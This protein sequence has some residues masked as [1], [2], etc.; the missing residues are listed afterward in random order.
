[1]HADPKGKSKQKGSRGCR[2]ED[3]SVCVG[4]NQSTAASEANSDTHEQRRGT[5]VRKVKFDN[6]NEG[7][8]IKKVFDP[9]NMTVDQAGGSGISMVCHDDCDEVANVTDDLDSGMIALAEQWDKDHADDPRTD[10]EAFVELLKDDP[11]ER[12]NPS[13]VFPPPQRPDFDDEAEIAALRQRHWD[14]YHS[15]QAESSSDTTSDTVSVTTDNLPAGTSSAA[16]SGSP[17]PDQE[18]DPREPTNGNAK[19]R[20]KRGAYMTAKRWMKSRAKARPA[21]ASENTGGFDLSRIPSELRPRMHP[22]VLERFVNGEYQPTEQELQVYER[23]QRTKATLVS[24][25]QTNYKTAVRLRNDQNIFAVPG[26]AL[27]DSGADIGVGISRAIA[28]QLDITWDEPYVMHGIGGSGGCLGRSSKKI[29]IHIGGDGRIDDTN[30]DPYDGCFTLWVQPIIITDDICRSIGH[31]CLIGQAIWT[32]CLASQDYFEEVLDISPAWFRHKC[33]LLR[34]S[35]PILSRKPLKSFKAACFLADSNVY[36]EA[37]LDDC[38]KPAVGKPVDTKPAPLPAPTSSSKVLAGPSNEPTA[39][40]SEPSSSKPKAPATTQAKQAARKAAAALIAPSSPATEEDEAKF[41]RKQ[42]RKS[43][44]AMPAHPG[45]PQE[46]PIATHEQW[47][48]GRTARAARTAPALEPTTA[49]NVVPAVPM[50]A[51][52]TGDGLINAVTVGF[53]IADLKRSGRFNM[54]TMQ[55]DLSDQRSELLKHAVAAEAAKWQRQLDALSAQV[56]SLLQAQAPAR[57][58]AIARLAEPVRDI[59]PS[60]ALVRDLPVNAQPSG[61]ASTSYSQILREPAPVPNTKPA[62]PT[63]PVQPEAADPKGKAPANSPREP[64]NPTHAM[65][66][67]NRPAPAT[68]PSTEATTTVPPKDAA[69]KPYAT[70]VA[71]ASADGLEEWRSMKGGMS[72]EQLRAIAHKEKDKILRR[73]GTLPRKDNT[74]KKVSFELPVKS[75]AAAVVAALTSMPLAKAEELTSSP[76]HDLSNNSVMFWQLVGALVLWTVYTLTRAMAVTDRRWRRVIDFQL[77]LLASAWVRQMLGAQLSIL[78]GWR[79]VI[80]SGY[81]PV[82]FSGVMLVILLAALTWAHAERKLFKKALKS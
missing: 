57:S 70:S 55:L 19:R 66:T 35:V 49:S 29:C 40:P 59:R 21:K 56:A 9:A 34:T 71:A 58:G 79:L 81:A 24:V 62:E 27:I 28:E 8:V 37:F 39:V 43:G 44:I 50:A 6:L 23:M 63:A 26:A 17:S 61:G 77:L 42:K 67:R 4:A 32:R 72:F 68:R 48:A 53:N 75:A 80:A 12:L 15:H 76:T 20:R 51:A 10:A 73:N 54:A 2:S 36:E 3:L 33:A 41:T 18:G 82:A 1:M 22:N 78:D 13:I 30:T 47:Q 64:R 52:P 46:G 31:S 38:G 45:F 65:S 16:H 69:P 60:P 5:R 25:V 11:Q 74:R 14:E 7:K